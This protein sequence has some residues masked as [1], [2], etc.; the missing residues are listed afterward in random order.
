MLRLALL[1]SLPVTKR[2]SNAR[3]YGML[4]A[5]G[6]TIGRPAVLYDPKGALPYD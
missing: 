6:V 4:T 1:S 5:V 3:P 2:A